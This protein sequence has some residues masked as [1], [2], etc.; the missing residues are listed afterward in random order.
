MV[1]LSTRYLGLELKC[2]VVVG[3]C[4][5]TSTVSKIRELEDSGVGGIV[6]KS[7]FEEQILAELDMNLEGYTSDYPEAADYIR[8]YTRDNAVEKYLT[9][10]S[11]VKKSVEIPVIA[12]INCVS[13][14]EWVTFA[15]EIEKAGADAIELNISMLPSNP[16][17]SCTDAEKSYIETV[18]KVAA[19][20]S[21]PLALKM[22]A[23]SSGLAHL[24][25]TLGWKKSISGFVLFN[26]Y[27]RPDID[28]NKM[29][30]TAAEVFSVEQ[31]IHETLRW[32]ALLASRVDKDFI[33]GTGVHDHTGVIKQL[34]AGATAV[35]I[36]SAYYKNG[37]SHTESILEGLKDWMEEKSYN[38]LDDFRGK[39]GYTELENP[40][41]FERTQFM[42]YFGGI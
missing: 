29:T 5:L 34:L 6:L 18:E 28:I 13:G 36:V 27:Y 35:Q 7:L 24:I 31:E 3:S 25:T 1:D 14:N 26:R 19:V 12:S 38:C 8:G 41:V 37:A 39:L 40:A 33:A 23:F 17:V 22:S 2:P 10:I 4:G 9:L 21:V 16:R 11:E 20:A 32:I 30:F 15:S 42:R